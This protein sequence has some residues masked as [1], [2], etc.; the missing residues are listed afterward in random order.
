MFFIEFVGEL[1]IFTVAIHVENIK[2]S[3]KVVVDIELRVKDKR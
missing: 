1:E 3:R 2:D